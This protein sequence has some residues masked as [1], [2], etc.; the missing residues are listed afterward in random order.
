MVILKSILR[1][2]K[3][4]AQRKHENCTVRQRNTTDRL[5]AAISRSNRT[6]RRDF[7]T[8]CVSFGTT[9][10]EFIG[11]KGAQQE[12]YRNG[13]PESPTSINCNEVVPYYRCI[14]ARS[15]YVETSISFSP[16]VVQI[17]NDLQEMNQN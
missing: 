11:H 9:I 10:A 7:S 6:S 13:H 3:F 8:E 12:I 14:C 4:S 1:N 17:G 15:V 16:D 2:L 5:F